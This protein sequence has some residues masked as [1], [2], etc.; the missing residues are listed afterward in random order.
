DIIF[1]LGYNNDY[2]SDPP[3]I[4]AQDVFLDM[5][6][7]PVFHFSERLRFISEV[8]IET[9]NPPTDDRV[10]EDEGLFARIL[11]LEYDVTDRFSVHAGKMT[12]SFALASFVIPGMF[13]NSYNR[14]I[15]LIDQV[16]IGGTYTF[17]GGDRGRHS[18]TFNTFF[19]D[20]SITSESLGNNRGRTTLED[21]GASNTEGFDSFALSLEGDAMERFPGLTYKLGYVHRAKGVDG[22]A[23]EN[24]I[25]A[26]LMQ[27]FDTA[28]G[29]NWTIVGEI[30][31]LENF[32]GTADDVVYASAGVTYR[33][34]RWMGILSG[35]YRPRY[36]ADG[37]DFD[38]DYTVQ[39]HVE[40]DLGRGWSAAIGHEFNRDQ[41]ADNRT[42]GLRL[43]KTIDLSNLGSTRDQ[44]G[45]W[46][47]LPS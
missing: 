37:D 44:L 6:A 28:D 22:V 43:S 47:H 4:E 8:R 31:A 41:G 34:D 14:E 19:E 18:L 39:V 2:E 25:S 9:I 21:G 35:T 26:T 12:P 38:D 30:A 23:D 36:V 13:G 10:F 32:E 1:R 5:I 16:G 15:E 42:L 24:G 45:Y 7:S 27:T 40:Y 20:T 46:P 3:L 29:E 33:K 17:G 11:L